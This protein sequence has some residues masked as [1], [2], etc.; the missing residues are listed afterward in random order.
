MADCIAGGVDIL[1]HTAPQS[2]PWTSEFVARLKAAHLALIPTL[3]LFDVESRKAGD[4][5]RDREELIAKVVDELRVFSQ[6]RGEVIFGTDVGYTDHF[7]TAMEFTLMSRAG[8]S[9]PQILASLF[10]QPG[11]A[12]LL[13][14]DR[15]H[16]HVMLGYSDSNKD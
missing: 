8:M 1:A 7:D 15:R 9:F 2:P 11:Y 5:D 10:A 13:A 3:T 16:Q 14:R 12:P 4:S 6:A